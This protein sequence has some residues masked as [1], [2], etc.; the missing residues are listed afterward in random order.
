M[1][2]ALPALAL[3]LAV[4]GCTGLDTEQARMC[5]FVVPALEPSEVTLGIIATEPAPGVR[6]AVQVRFSARDPDGTLRRRF[7]VCEFGGGTFSERRTRLIGL[8]TDE[9]AFSPGQILIL[10]RFW[11]NA[12]G[13][14]AEAAAR[15]SAVETHPPAPWAFFLQGLVNGLPG[16]AILALLAT[17][18]ALLYGLAGRINLAFG[19]LAVVG[20]YGALSAVAAAATLGGGEALVVLAAVLA[21]VATAALAT[22]V[23][24][25]I[26]IRPLIREPGRMLLVA[27]IGVSLMLQEGLRIAQGAGQRWLPP[28]MGEPL[29]LVQAGGFAVI[30]TVMQAAVFGSALVVAGV[31]AVAMGRLPFGRAWRAFADDALAARLCGLDERAV[32]RTTM[33]LAGALAGTCGAIIVFGY[34]TAHYAMG[35]VLGLK[36]IVA[37][38]LGGIG[39]VPGALLGG[40]TIGLAEGLWSAYLPIEYR[41][42]VIFGLVAV[43][44]GFR[45]GGFFGAGGRDQRPV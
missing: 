18:Y 14:A 9:G 41:D 12:P 16:A 44:L 15:L 37:A 39:S 29:V 13:A 10:E 36:A 6:N 7:A 38:I 20:A 45:P 42:A 40:L 25:S 23:V 3:A 5:R 19:D 31:A 2:R 34:G 32:L 1:P 26:V 43:L 22:R 8:T 11:L 35:T 33:L 4:A 28:V 21:A 24:G 17:A 30:L 27:T